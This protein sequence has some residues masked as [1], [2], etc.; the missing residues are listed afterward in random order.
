MRIPLANNL[1]TRDGTL[2]KDAKIVNGF[3]ESRGDD[4]AVFKR[5]G[6]TNLGPVGTGLGQLLTTWNESIYSV[7]GDE[8]GQSLATSGS[9]TGRRLFCAIATQSNNISA[10]SPD[11][12]TWTLGGFPAVDNWTGIA[13]NGTVFCAI[14]GTDA[15]PPGPGSTN[16]ATSTDGLSWTLRTLPVSASW[17]AIA[18]NGSVFCSVAYNSTI[19]AT[20]PDGITWT[21][22]TLPVSTGWI[23]IAWNGVNFVALSETGSG[24]AAT[25]PD[26]ITWTQ[27]VFSTTGNSGGLVA[28][29]ENFYFVN[30]GLNAGKS[31]NNGVGWL[32]GTLPGSGDFWRGVAT[33]SDSSVIVAV[34]TISNSYRGAISS[35]GITWTPITTPAAYWRTVVHNGFEFCAISGGYRDAVTLVTSNI[36]AT[37][38][39]GVTWTQRTLP[40]SANWSA[41]CVGQ[42]L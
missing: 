37:S 15:I 35:D 27:Q 31:V 42:V 5:P 18:W 22:R 19:A 41:M 1:V 32:A 20:S 30:S 14:A 17:S 36:A 33:N 16:A 28:S 7:V 10:I 23:S 12:A 24:I 9:F 26:G 40:A 38:L 11:G 25:S 29:N 3:V 21:Q 8:L 4:S 34:S 39:D 2:T 13:W 6:T